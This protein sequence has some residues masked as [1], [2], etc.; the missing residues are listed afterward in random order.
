LIQSQKRLLEELFYPQW[1][2]HKSLQHAQHPA[3]LRWKVCTD[4]LDRNGRIR[5]PDDIE[6][7]ETF[8]SAWLD[9]IT[10][11]LASGGSVDAQE[12]GNLANYG[13]KALSI[14]GSRR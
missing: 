7:L 6:I 3:Y 2:S 1:F 10:L 11:I 12:L 8:L 4:L 14:S 5:V 9:N 13:D